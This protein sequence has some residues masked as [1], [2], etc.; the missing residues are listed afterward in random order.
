[1]ITVREPARDIPVAGEY[2]TLLDVGQK[3]AVALIYIDNFDEALSSIEEVRRSL[4][5][6]HID[7]KINKYMSS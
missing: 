7:R 2:D 6:A 1:M 5:V 3:L 4:L